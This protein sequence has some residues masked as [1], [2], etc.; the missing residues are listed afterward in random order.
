MNVFM[1]FVIAE[2]SCSYDTSRSLDYARDDKL[3][4]YQGNLMVGW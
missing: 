3:N 2:K 1:E 4:Q